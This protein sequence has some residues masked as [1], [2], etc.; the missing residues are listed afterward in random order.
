MQYE[1]ISSAYKNAHPQSKKL[2]DKAIKFLAGGVSASG[3]FYS[4]HPLYFKEMKG[5]K[6]IDVDGNEYV[7]FLMNFGSLIL[8]HKHPSVVSAIENATDCGIWFGSPNELEIELAEK[9]EKYFH[10]ISKIRFLN[11]GSE[12]VLNALRVARGFTGKD[13]IA[14]FEGGYHGHVDSPLVS[15]SPLLDLAGSSH[16]PKAVPFGKGITKDAIKNT[17]VLPYNN[18]EATKEIIE[19]NSDDL[20]AVIVEAMQGFSG[21]IPAKKEFLIAL[22]KITKE[23]G[24]LLIFDEVIT[25]FRLALGGA[26]EYFNITP[27]MTILGKIIGGGLPIGAFGG[28]EEI[29]E[30]VLP[31]RDFKTSITKRVFQSGTFSGHPMTMATGLATVAE[32]EKNINIYKDL[33][34]LTEEAKK[35]LRDIFTDAN[36]GAQVTG[37]SS[38]FNIHFVDH[39]VT[40][41]RDVLQGDIP[42]LVAFETGL[43][44]EG[45]FIMPIIAHFVLTSAHKQQDIIKLHETAEN[46]INKIKYANITIIK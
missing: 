1:E 7:D 46:V 41:V 42:K 26:Q 4:P 3:R 17:I 30:M 20:A 45:I 6:I 8:G 27:D 29:M 38:L 22:R 43:I 23:H 16:E 35:G 13:K 24:I 25:G 33:E 31:T 39:E 44:N 37:I 18:I 14:K 12:A 21:S 19:R 32:L 2:Y 11:S 40:S 9:I 34:R 5:S 36:V 15:L 10:S 28:K